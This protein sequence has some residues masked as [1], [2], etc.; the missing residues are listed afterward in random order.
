M[1]S[2]MLSLHGS[3]SSNFSS[4]PCLGCSCSLSLALS[5]LAS[6]LDSDEEVEPLQDIAMPGMHGFT[7]TAMPANVA[8]EGELPSDNEKQCGSPAFGQ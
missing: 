5:G 2:P 3:T 4:C 1:S 6:G 7:G 8:L